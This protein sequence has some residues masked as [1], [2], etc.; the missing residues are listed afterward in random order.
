MRGVSRYFLLACALNLGLALPA[1]AKQEKD[2]TSG[3][4]WCEN[5]CTAAMEIGA[6]RCSAFGFTPQAAICHAANMAYYG[7]CLS[8]CRQVWGS[9]LNSDQVE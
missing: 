7:G 5:S 6:A 2:C 8:E 3:R 1:G 9:G 4:E